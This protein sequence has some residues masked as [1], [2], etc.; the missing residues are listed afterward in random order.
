[1]Q[2]QQKQTVKHEN[3]AWEFTFQCSHTRA[4]S[5]E[6]TTIWN[7]VKAWTLGEKWLNAICVIIQNL[8]IYLKAIFGL[9]VLIAMNIIQVIVLNGKESTDFIQNLFPTKFND[10]LGLFHIN[11]YI[12]G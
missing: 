6:V 2:N 3:T 10:W 8:F 12:W 7:Q 5:K 11:S 1:M 4:L 9:I